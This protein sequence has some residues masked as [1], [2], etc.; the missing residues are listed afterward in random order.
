[1]LDYG[2]REFNVLMLNIQFKDQ[3]IFEGLSPTKPPLLIC[4]I[5]T[6]KESCADKNNVVL[7]Y[8]RV[9]SMCIIIIIMI[10]RRDFCNDD[11][12]PNLQ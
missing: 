11:V 1:M 7:C 6:M 2:Y 12:H 10:P 4:I 8:R 9:R 5:F 3:G